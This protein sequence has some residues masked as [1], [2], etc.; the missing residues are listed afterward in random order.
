M[1]ENAKGLAE[2]AKQIKRLKVILIC[3][4]QD[5]EVTTVSVSLLK[6]LAG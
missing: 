5:E 3:V 2:L 1:P 4:E 6:D